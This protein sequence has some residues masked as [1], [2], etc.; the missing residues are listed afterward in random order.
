MVAGSGQGR[1]RRGERAA[2]DVEHRGRHPA[3]PARLPA[4]GRRRRR[5][6]GTLPLHLARAAGSA[7]DRGGRR[8]GPGPSMVRD[9]CASCPG[10]RRS[11][12]AWPSRETRKWSCNAGA[13]RRPAWRMARPVCSCPGSV[14]CPASRCAWP[15]CSSTW[16]VWSARARTRRSGSA[17]QRC[18]A[19]W[20]CSPTTRFRW[21]GGRS[22]RPHFPK[23]SGTRA[24]SPA[25][26]YASV[27]ALRC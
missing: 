13:R 6:C 15:W 25:G 21:P 14:S 16:L 7:L 3:G 10:S 8:A 5:A 17:P 11:Q 26:C 9:G 27:R 1:R 20:G 23:P 22:A 12:C 4:A 24:C 18:C 19:R 2:P